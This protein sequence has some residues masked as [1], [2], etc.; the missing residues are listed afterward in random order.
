[1][2]RVHTLA[3]TGGMHNSG[4]GSRVTTCY[5]LVKQEWNK[6]RRKNLIPA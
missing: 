6:G 1:M 4:T 2:S 3:T 5:Q